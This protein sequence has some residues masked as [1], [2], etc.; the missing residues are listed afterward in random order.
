VASLPAPP[1]RRRL[2]VRESRTG[3]TTPAFAARLRALRPCGRLRIIDGRAEG[4]SGA[5]GERAVT[6]AEE[7]HGPYDVE[8]EATGYAI[9]ARNEP[10]LAGLGLEL[11]D[12]LPVLDGA[13]QGL[14][15]LHLAG[16]LAELEL[17]PAG[18]NLW[19]AARRR[20]ATPSSTT[21]PLRSA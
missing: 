1:D 17:G 11:C 21:A 9:S 14:P 10:L 3:S 13:L 4:I 19:G 6:T 18:R 2:R 5:P 16:A 12:G 15:G 20:A 7:A 8:Y